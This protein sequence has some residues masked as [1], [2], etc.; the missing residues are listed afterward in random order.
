MEAVVRLLG[1]RHDTPGMA[2]DS[3]IA[4]AGVIV[5]DVAGVETETVGGGTFPCADELP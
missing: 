1:D 4:L 3:D 5:K 2:R